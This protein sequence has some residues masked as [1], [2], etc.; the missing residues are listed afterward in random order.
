[1]ESVLITGANRGI[2][3]ALTREFLEH[4]Y[5]VW[6]GARTPNRAADL[7]ALAHGAEDRLTLLPLDVTRPASVKAACA[8]VARRTDALDILINNAGIH[9]ESGEERFEHMDLDHFRR[10]FET[11]TLGAM[12]ATQAFLPLLRRSRH[13]RLV[14]IS[15]GAGSISTKTDFS[16]Y[17]YSVSKAALNMWT[18]ALANELKLEGIIVVALSPGWVRTDMGGPDATLSAGESARA[19]VQTVARLRPRQAGRFLDRHGRSRIYKW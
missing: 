19:I 8:R 3:L 18:R 4:G 6:A 10:A 16:R 2:G 15:S 12:R 1:M 11:N 7:H 13:A 17:A 9:P 5:R 14:N